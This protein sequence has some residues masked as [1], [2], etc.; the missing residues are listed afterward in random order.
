MT[1]AGMDK[2]HCMLHGKDQLQAWHWALTH[3]NLRDSTPI[4]LDRDRSSQ[5]GTLDTHAMAALC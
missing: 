1:A 4:L 2:R 5:Q 3:I